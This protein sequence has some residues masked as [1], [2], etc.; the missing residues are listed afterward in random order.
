LWRY[1]FGEERCIAYK[2]Y[3]AICP[4]LAI[5]A[6]A[7]TVEAEEQ[8]DGGWRT[9]RYDIDITKCIY[10]GSV[11]ARSRPGVEFLLVAAADNSRILPLDAIVECTSQTSPGS[12]NG[13]T[14]D[15]I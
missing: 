12:R 5:T 8:G 3:G 10:Y 9:T 11:R 14:D 4:V 15:N 2:L 1:P 7:I 6:L 13:S